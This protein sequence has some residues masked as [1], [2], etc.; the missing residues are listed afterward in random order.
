MKQLSL[1]LERLVQR[2]KEKD[3]AKKPHVKETEASDHLKQITNNDEGRSVK[4]VDLILG[5]T[6]PMIGPEEKTDL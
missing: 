4:K 5:Q 2:W 1:R 3:D 6:Q